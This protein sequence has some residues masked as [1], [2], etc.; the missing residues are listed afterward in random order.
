MAD[1]NKIDIIKK[2]CFSILPQLY[3]DDFT[4]TEQIDKLVYALNQLI[5][6]NAMLEDYVK[7]VIQTIIDNGEIQDVIE[8]I[9]STC[10][11]NV[12][13]PPNGIIPASGDGTTDDTLSIQG[14]IDYAKSK[15]GACV[16]FPSGSYLTQPLTL[17]EKVTIFGCSQ[18]N[19]KLVLKGGV[20]NALISVTEDKAQIRG[21]DLDAN[22][23]SQVNDINVCNITAPNC[24]IEDCIIEN[25]HILINSNANLGVTIIN[26]V[27][28]NG[29]GYKSIVVSGTNL[30]TLK[31]ITINTM[32]GVTGD[33]A[34]EINSNNVEADNIAILAPVPKGVVENGSYCKFSGRIT[35]AVTKIVNN[36]QMNN[37]D[38]VGEIHY[39]RLTGK[40]YLSADSKDELLLNDK[41]VTAKNSTETLTGNKTVNAVSSTETLTGNKTV[42]SINNTETLTGSKTVNAVGS[43]EV[44]TGSKSISAIN[45]TENLTGNKIKNAVNNTETYTG[46]SSVN[47]KNITYVA[48][49]SLLLSGLD[50]GINPT[51]PLRYKKPVKLNEQFNYISFKDPDN[52]EYKVLVQGNNISGFYTNVADHGVKGDSVTDDTTAFQS[53]INSLP[54]GGVLFIPAGFRC[55]VG[56]LTVNK[57]INIV[58]NGSNELACMMIAKTDSTGILNITSVGVNIK[59]IQFDSLTTQRSGSYITITG[60]GRG[61]ISECY[62]GRYYIGITHNG[63]INEVISDCFFENGTSRLLAS[64]G[65]AILIGTTTYTSS[66]IIEN[67]TVTS[68]NNVP[69]E[70]PDYGLCLKYV[71]GGF[72]NNCSFI[73]QNM[74]LVLN[75]E[76]TQ[77]THAIYVSNTIFDSSRFGCTLTPL[78]S[79]IVEIISFTN[80]WFSGN[81]EM[82]LRIL[83]DSTG[84]IAGINFSN[85]HLL[86]NAFGAYI[87]SGVDRLNISNS[88]IGG[89]T[90]AGILVT[91]NAK[92]VV[93]NSNNVGPFGDI[94]ANNAGITLGGDC[95]KIIINN[96]IVNGNT[97]SQISVGTTGVNIIKE[98]NLEV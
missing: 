62:F 56:T 73:K 69:D 21:L 80:C 94:I 19:T 90:N 22:A 97:V 14:C 44:L 48:D 27:V 16:Y 1:F 13:F 20:L 51:N 79:A 8:N 42:N 47:S 91:G 9:L 26:N 71:D 85:C 81:T 36:G 24:Y 74:P 63:T 30:V 32:S 35:N 86:V 45:S 55:L 7:E 50:I 84:K 38:M 53:A 83:A 49:E 58:G 12:K 66:P 93:I 33:T 4:I 77:F 98:H 41:S 72:I 11:I 64:G 15:N 43:S 92:N 23:G 25:G 40:D 70:A 60:P 82:G 68:V 28:C 46:D 34:I 67:V 76:S 10:I 3:L 37:N 96:N 39:S 17:K 78:G 75:P 29:G 6:N 65:C 2:C 54:D 95:D 5:E 57:P 52:I 18:F 87:G 61:K 31:N 88:T 59:N 89:N